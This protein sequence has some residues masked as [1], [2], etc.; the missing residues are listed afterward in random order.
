MHYF[1]PFRRQRVLAERRLC[2]ETGSFGR[3]VNMNP[4]TNA[5]P[6]AEKAAPSISNMTFEGFA[7]MLK[8][9]LQNYYQ[10]VVSRHKEGMAR[11]AA[12]RARMKAEGRRTFGRPEAGVDTH[13]E[14]LDE[15]MGADFD[16]VINKIARDVFRLPETQSGVLQLTGLMQKAWPAFWDIVQDSPHFSANPPLFRSSQWRGNMRIPGAYINGELASMSMARMGR[17]RRKKSGVFDKLKRKPTQ[18]YRIENNV[19]MRY[20]DAAASMTAEQFGLKEEGEDWTP[21]SRTEMGRLRW[22]AVQTGDEEAG[23]P[24][25]IEVTKAAKY[26]RGEPIPG[27]GGKGLVMIEGDLDT[28]SEAP[29]VFIDYDYVDSMIALAVGHPF[30]SKLYKEEGYFP[31]GAINDIALVLQNGT[32]TAADEREWKFYANDAVAMIIM[33]APAL[34]DIAEIMN[35]EGFSTAENLAKLDGLSDSSARDL[36]GA[37]LVN[38]NVNK[39]DLQRVLKTLCKGYIEDTGDDWWATM[40]TDF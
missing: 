38:P 31:Q 12:G 14:S 10:S 35:G 18:Q 34:Q 13:S 27:S 6:N 15:Q 39:D 30:Y 17:Y 32:E 26:D 29:M 19:P 22:D 20:S 21:K 40:Q 33:E 8:S 24:H 11:R 5:Y 2:A 16:R 1:S 9:N 3:E 25:F 37:L 4:K 36:I 7:T 23:T 28:P